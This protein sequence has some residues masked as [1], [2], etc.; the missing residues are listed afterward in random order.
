MELDEVLQKRRSIRKY[1]DRDVL[2]SD[3]E[4]IISAGCLAPSAHNRQPW[5]VVVVKD[6]KNVIV[7]CMIDYSNKYSDDISIEKT[8]RT[9]ERANVILLVYCTSKVQYEYDL[10][11]MGAFIENMLLKATELG[12]G[13]LW[14]GN[15]CPMANRISD[16]LQINTD[17]KFLVSAVALGYLAN[18]VVQLE[19]KS[20]SDVTQY[21]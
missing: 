7:D 14:I 5:E 1:I 21:L 9:I 13:S 16:K 18:D 17:D 4:Q 12:I 11:S 6:R 3:I 15:V 20:A 2:K 8:A 19:R 10:L